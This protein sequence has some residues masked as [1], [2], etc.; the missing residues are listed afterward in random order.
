MNNE[1]LEKYAGLSDSQII[2]IKSSDNFWSWET[3]PVIGARDILIMVQI[4]LNPG[5][6]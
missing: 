4:L 5:S 3:G 2:K 1:Y 6:K